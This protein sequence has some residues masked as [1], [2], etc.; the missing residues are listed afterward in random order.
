MIEDDF[1]EQVN[2]KGAFGSHNWMEEWSGMTSYVTMLNLEEK[3]SHVISDEISLL[4]NYPNPFN[5]STE[6]AFEFGKSYEIVN[7]KVFNLMGQTVFE[8]SIKNV[9]AGQP[10]Y[11]HAPPASRY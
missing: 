4:G 5:P 3:D 8:T 7:L 9:R 10:F 6:I 11:Y 1:F 2:Y